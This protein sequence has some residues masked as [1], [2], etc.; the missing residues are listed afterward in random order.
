MAAITETVK[1]VKTVKTEET[2]KTDKPEPRAP[3]KPSGKVG[4]TLALPHHHAGWLYKA[5]DKLDV[6]P[7]Q[8]TWLA[9]RGVI[10][11]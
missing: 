11:E 6:W 7:A 8:K 1:T 5:G 4:V 3:Q 2:V 9:Q 10:A